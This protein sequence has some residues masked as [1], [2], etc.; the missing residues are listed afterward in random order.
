MFKYSNFIMSYIIIF[1]MLVMKPANWKI[2]M[3][4]LLSVWMNLAW[5]QQRIVGTVT[6]QEDK[7][8]LSGVSVTVKGKGTG[9]QTNADG[10]F[11]LDVSK[12]DVLIVSYVGYASREITVGAAN[13]LDV[14]L[15]PTVSK[16]DEVVVV[17]YGTQSRRKVANS[18]SSVDQKVLQSVPRTNL[19]TA[20]QGTAAGLRVQ[21]STGQPGSTPT[22][23]L[24]GGTNF[25]GSGSPLF[26]VDGV[27]VPSLYGLNY[28]DVESIDVLK[29]AASLAIYGARAGNGVVLVNTRKGKKGRS[30]VS[31]TYR[32]ANNMVRRNP[33]DFMSAQDY[34]LWN[35]A[36]LRSR[37]LLGKLA[38]DVDTASTK[39]QIFGAHPNEHR[40]F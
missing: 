10:R 40:L 6:S 34:I 7:A 21:Q 18:V 5:S 3:T 4:L 25:N 13:T 24:R 8:P 28:D 19:A 9:T 35:R 26:V 29:D 37:Y 22:I 2:V 14:A 30:Q 27:I 11:T 15:Q 32:Q 39:N 12:G 17:G 38:G 20:L 36:G 23:I 31:Y 33:V 1:K 16:M